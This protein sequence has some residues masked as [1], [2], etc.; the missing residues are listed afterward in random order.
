MALMF[1]CPGAPSAQVGTFLTVLMVDLYN[2]IFNCLI[3]ILRLYVFNNIFGHIY[4]L[5]LYH[6][7]CRI[8]SA[9]WLSYYYWVVKM[10]CLWDILLVCCYITDIP[11]TVQ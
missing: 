7:L 3:K 11:G 5:G 8:L 1:G 9:I 10:L 6:N 2:R 4:L